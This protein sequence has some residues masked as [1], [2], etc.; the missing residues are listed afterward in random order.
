MASQAVANYSNSTASLRSTITGQM[1]QAGSERENDM[2]AFTAE[3][4]Q[5]ATQYS[6]EKALELAPKT[7][8]GLSPVQKLVKRLTGKDTTPRLTAAK[9]AEKTKQAVASETDS[10][11]L[12]A[13]EKIAAA[14]DEVSKAQTKATETATELSNHTAKITAQD[15]Q[16]RNALGTL[17]SRQAAETQAQSLS[18]TAAA[19]VT[20]L[21]GVQGQANSLMGQGSG[22]LAEA[23]SRASTA[24]AAL[25]NAKEVTQSAQTLSDAA[26]SDANGLQSQFV[27]KSQAASDADAALNDAK[28]A[29]TAV[30]IEQ[31]AVKTA[32]I[33]KVAKDAK[34]ADEMS[35]E[36]D[37][38]GDPLALVAS[39][40][41][42]I[43]SYLIGRK[44]QVHTAVAPPKVITSQLASYAATIGA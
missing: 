14:T 7:I 4:L 20:R 35:A 25:N 39:A 15:S 27:A 18:D 2:K 21:G 8:G 31:D 42:A 44:V 22:D 36:V 16:A 32:R 19:E 37:E 26:T 13:N 40:A 38:T 30:E 34:L 23:T 17:Q 41:I 29:K 24:E 11:I 10:E 43:G 3:Q 12:D 28:G 6:K 1:Q 9:E 5:M 33:A